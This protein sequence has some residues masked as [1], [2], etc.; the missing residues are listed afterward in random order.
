MDE[1][2]KLMSDLDTAH[3]AIQ[4]LDIQPTKG[5]MTNMLFVL[6]TLE[7]AYQFVSTVPDVPAE[8]DDENA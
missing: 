8:K 3:K 4:D 2:Q 6:Q 7:K 1:K 5:N